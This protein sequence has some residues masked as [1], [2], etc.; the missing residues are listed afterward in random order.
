MLRRTK[1]I[2][3]RILKFTFNFDVLIAIR[4]VVIPILFRNKSAYAHNEY[5]HSVITNYLK[6]KYKKLINR[7]RTRNNEVSHS[8]SENYPVW[9]F[10][11]QGEESMPEII[12][13]CYQT[14]KYYSNGHTI[15]LITQNNYPDFADIPG[16]I[17]K[18]LNSKRITLTSFSDILRVCLLFEHGGLWLDSTILLTKPL[19]SL[20]EICKHLGFWSPKDNGNILKT[21]FRAGNWIIRESRWL[22]FCFYAS[23]HNVLTEFIREMYFSYL[24]KT[25]I[26]IDYFIIDYFINIAYDTI[27][28]VRVMIDS[29]PE[30]NPMIHEI[31]H[32]LNLNHEYNKILFDDVCKNTF[33]HKLTWKTEKGD[34]NKFTKNNKLTNYGHIINNF[35]PVKE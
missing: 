16:Y 3:I 34:F 32:R 23:K 27:S 14:L 5:K 18:K 30:N 25:N 9:F 1:E 29:V 26:L 4:L 28:D 6:K 33:F 24:K 10:W 13:I 35:P 31:Q 11:W 2:C 20:P 22:A 19:S 17:I 15:N 7:F 8:L 12:N 21:C